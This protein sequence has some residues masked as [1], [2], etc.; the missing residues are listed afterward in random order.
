M[1]TRVLRPTTLLA[2]LLI[3]AA[4]SALIIRRPRSADVATGDSTSF[5]ENLQTGAG[6]GMLDTSI[7]SEPFEGEPR[8][9]EQPDITHTLPTVESSESDGRGES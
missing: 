8:T 4:S 7:T 2:L 1:A 5:A 9:E 6:D 3:V